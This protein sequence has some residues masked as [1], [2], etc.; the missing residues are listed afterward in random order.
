MAYVTGRLLEEEARQ[1]EGK[2]TSPHTWNHPRS[3]GVKCTSYS[4][5]GGRYDSRK[6]CADLEQVV[7]KVQRCFCCGYIN[8]LKR[9]CLDARRREAASNIWQRQK[10]T[11]VVTDVAAGLRV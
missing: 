5:G 8:H 3:E 9:D 2:M 1:E 10:A 7:L 6:Q 4:N 11:L